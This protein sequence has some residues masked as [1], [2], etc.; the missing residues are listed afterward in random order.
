[1]EQQYRI[2]DIS[3]KLGISRDTLRFYE[4][5]GVI[6]PRKE[7]NGYRYYSY[8][9]VRILLDILFFRKYDFSLEEIYQLLNTSTYGSFKEKLQQKIEEET[10]HLEKKKRSLINLSINRDIISRAERYLEKYEVQPF[11]DFRLIKED[12]LMENNQ[13]LEL[14]Y[15]YDEYQLK[16]EAVEITKQYMLVPGH[17]A[18]GL[19]LDLSMAWNPKKV[20]KS[21]VYTI[22]ESDFYTL[23]PDKLMKSV[24]W[25]KKQGFKPEGRVLA[26][27]LLHCV[28]E[29]KQVYYIEL[30]IPIVPDKNSH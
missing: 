17:A 12:M 24:T 8:K 20:G 3:K 13:V 6:H 2:G 27:N 21:C 4:K 9:D 7:E 15:F 16:G 23:A 10:A 25:V 11:P 5:K 19:N 14:C 18:D 29:G 26:G 28:K 30:Y 1:M 22:V